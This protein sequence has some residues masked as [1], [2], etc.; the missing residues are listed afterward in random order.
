MGFTSALASGSFEGKYEMK[1][2]NH[3]GKLNI[4]QDGSKL[5]FSIGTAVNEYTCDAEGEAILNPAD[6]IATFKGE[7]DC[8]ISFKFEE[9]TVNVTTSN[10]ASYYCGV[11]GYMDGIFT[12]AGGKSNAANIAGASAGDQTP[13]LAQPE[14]QQTSRARKNEIAKY[15]IITLLF[16]SVISVI[17]HF[18]GKLVLYKDYTD[19]AVTVGGIVGSVLL[20]F[21]CTIFLGLSPKTT[22][23]VVLTF[24]IPISIFVFR[25]TYITN[26][27]IFFTT[28]SLLTKY[29]TTFIYAFLMA[30]LMF[31]GSSRKKGESQAAFEARR[32]REEREK[33]AW[34]AVLT[35]IFMWFVHATTKI[36]A[37]SPIEK[38]FAFSFQ[39]ID[40]NK[41]LATATQE[42]I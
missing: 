2:E 13:T 29:T 12:K 16:I 24:F 25:M 14:S 20:L 33:Q 7:G 4:T 21:I 15:I 10:C 26:S 6:N 31:S 19:A 22:W 38:Y 23:I 27:N 35:A 17:L 18:N 36:Q 8:S 1:E 32:R 9:N 3:G 40:I 42:E 30:S 28:L 11:G 37:W 39:K 5:K 41:E 34:M